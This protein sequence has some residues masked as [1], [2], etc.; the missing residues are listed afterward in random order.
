[1]KVEKAYCL[2]EQSGTF[3]N[4]FKS[5]GIDAYDFDILDDFKETD[6]VVDLFNEI[7]NAYN[8]IPSIFDKFTSNDIVIAFFPC[9]RF[10][11]Q[12]SLK[13]RGEQYHDRRLPMLQR[14]QNVIPLEEER[15][16]FYVLFAKLC[17]VC[18]QRKLRII[19][20]NPYATQHYLVRYFPL[21]AVFV[22][23]DRTSRGDVFKKPT[24]YWFINCEPSYNIIF[25]PLEY[26][27]IKTIEYTRN[28]VERSMISKEYANRFIR[29]FIL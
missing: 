12:I 26:K 2:F 17:C 18:I 6:F 19:I 23:N 13:F 3:K 10:E 22:D 8:G 20:E 16:R 9:T 29:E 21:K 15:C 28:K 5:L 24:Q 14:I 25:E 1:M 4:E 11:A 27:K 7:N